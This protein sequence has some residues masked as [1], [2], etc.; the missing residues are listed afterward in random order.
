MELRRLS[1]EP[2]AARSLAVAAA[3]AV[4]S[5]AVAPA[6]FLAAGLPPLLTGAACLAGGGVATVLVS[7]RIRAAVEPRD[8]LVVA[9]LRSR[10][11][12][13]PTPLDSAAAHRLGEAGWAF[14]RVCRALEIAGL[15][16]QDLGDALR[17]APE[18]VESAF[19]GI[20]SD[21]EA[22]EEAVEEAA[23]LL[24]NLNTSMLR[25]DQ[26]VQGLSGAAEE[27][28]SS[29]LEL[30]SSIDEVARNAGALHQS[31]DT[32]ASSVHEMTASIRQVAESA[33]SVQSMA[34]ES[35]TS[36]VE[37]DRAIQEVGEH[38]KEASHLTQQLHEE[39]ERG[40]REVSAT[41][42]GIREIRELTGDAKSVLG[43]LAERIGEIGEIV[44]VISSI[45]DETNLLSLNAAIIAAQAGEQGKAFAVVANHVK[46]LAQR[47]ASSTQEI[48]ALIGSVQQES[49]NA[50][51]AMQAGTQ[52]VETGVQR[53]RKAG[54]ALDRI[55]ESAEGASSRV[56]EISRAATE[57][58]RNSRHVTQ[59]AQKTSAM[60]QQINQ[61]M[62]E[63]SAASENLLR[64][65][66]AA[67]ETCRQVHRST[68]EQ[69]GSSGL[70]A[71]SVDSMR[72]RIESIQRSTEAHSSASEPLAQAVDR[73]L[74][75]ARKSAEPVP[76]ALRAL[77]ALRKQLEAPE[78]PAAQDPEE[79]SSATD[80]PA[81]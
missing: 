21:A 79:P 19:E 78:P 37:M 34:E 53:S 62:A 81:R 33:D 15:R 36:M 13:T 42:D 47:T 64:S 71:R 75:L 27:V 48:A 20:R 63:Q 51:E 38:V 1:P 45:N 3:A 59:A 44:D 23:S 10:P 31:V 30:T 52:A 41:I 73:I 67:L 18:R 43:R 22:Q 39:A 2:Q 9:L 7:R 16:E 35:A 24:V 46:T 60:T 49:G 5:V 61:A 70:I 69:R 40:S 68:E 4:L 25:V 6:L 66:E 76:D 56:S 17:G 28:S 26:E 54:E 8:A 14:N 77:R 50:L 80:R 74:G 65:A 12:T 58:A 29:V 11:D 57:Q 32:S 55:R 72:E